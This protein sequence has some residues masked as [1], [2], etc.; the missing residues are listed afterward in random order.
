MG[1]V[2]IKCSKSME[3]LRKE[4]S[5]LKKV[6]ELIKAHNDKAMLEAACLNPKHCIGY[7]VFHWIIGSFVSVKL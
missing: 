1:E 5:L 6:C 3:T 4:C 7:L 2:Q